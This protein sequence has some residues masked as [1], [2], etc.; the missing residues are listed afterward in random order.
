MDNH[1]H[2]AS[3]LGYTPLHRGSQSSP[4][5]VA[6]DSLAHRLADGKSHTRP[7]IVAA[8]TIEHGH[9]PRKLLF[10]F[11]VHSLEIRMLAQPQLLGK[12]P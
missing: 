11:L 7:G 8:L 6:I 3:Q 5:A 4:D 2:G 9:I 1:V 12:L 10:P